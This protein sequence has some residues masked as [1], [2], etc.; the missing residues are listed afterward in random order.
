MNSNPIH[1]IPAALLMCTG[2]NAQQGIAV[3]EVTFASTWSAVTHPVNFPSNPHFSPLIGGTHD[4]STRFW[5]SGGLAT[6]G[7]EQMAE[8][9]GTSILRAEIQA[10]INSGGA[11]G[12]V[13]GGGLSTSPSS[14][15]V[16][17][18]ISAS[19]PHFTIVSMLAPSPDWFVGLSGLNLL[20]N[21]R[22]L[23]TA[24]VAAHL[25]DAGTD[26]GTTYTSANSNTNP[27][28]KIA[29]V[30]TTSGPFKGRSTRV[31]TFT[32]KRIA[33][34][35]VYGC[36]VNPKGSMTVISGVPLLG[37]SV[38]FA[39]HD[40]LNSMGLGAQTHLFFSVTPDRGFPCGFRI[41]GFG[42]GTLGSSGE[43]LIGGI[44]AVLRGAAWQGSPVPFALTV[45][46]QTS[47]IGASAYVQGALTTPNRVGVTDAVEV[48]LGR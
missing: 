40:P 10:A 2:L 15:T 43:I 21:G 48:H 6:P 7:I 5:M 42:L 39:V 46:N 16:R 22:W 17:F 19:H 26:N 28:Q 18:T 32:V 37:Q 30:T 12:I 36:G 47:V 29:L 33:G 45:P 9:G 14:R 34:T 8:T 25:Y 24:V 38:T 44:V 41:P 4:P 1:L 23:D 31:G 11:K 20:A 27:K 35:K 3:Y 13:A